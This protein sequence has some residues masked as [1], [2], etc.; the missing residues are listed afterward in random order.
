MTK[1]DR[2]R[3]DMLIRVRDFG[4]QHGQQFAENSAAPAAFAVVSAEIERLAALNITARNASEA[5]RVADKAAA[6]RVLGDVLIRAGQTARVIAR[7]TPDLTARVP[8]PLPLA[9]QELITLARQFAERATPHVERF[10]ALGIQLADLD[11]GIAT[12]EQAVHRRGKGRNERVQTRAQVEAAFTRAY[13]AVAILDV[14]V[15]NC[16]ASDPVA[17]AVW[18]HGRRVPYARRSTTPTMPEAAEAPE[19]TPT[20]EATFTP[21]DETPAAPA[22]PDPGAADAVA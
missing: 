5:S 22:V 3:Y 2:Q 16:L 9:D 7:T 19:P 4:A 13:D 17:L 8:T 12:F 1:Q 14:S 21:L 10:A 15:A 18:K 20:P 6:R 11:T